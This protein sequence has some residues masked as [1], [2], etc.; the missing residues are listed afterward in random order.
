MGM[1][2]FGNMSTGMRTRAV[3]PTTATISATT[4]MKYGVRMAKR[5]IVSSGRSGRADVSYLGPYLA[6]GA[7]T[8]A[9]TND[10]DIAF[11]KAGANLEAV[12]SLDAERNIAQFQSSIGS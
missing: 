8:C 2:M 9:I 1:L 12:R 10:H 5:D 11:P 4:T 6:A 7:Q 3:P